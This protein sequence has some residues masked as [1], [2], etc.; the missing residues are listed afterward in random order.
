MTRTRYSHLTDEELLSETEQHF[1]NDLIVELR[2]RL[3][4]KIDELETPVICHLCKELVDLN[5]LN[6]EDGT[7]L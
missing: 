3:A 6:K 7:H 4:D 5:T 2:E 1:A